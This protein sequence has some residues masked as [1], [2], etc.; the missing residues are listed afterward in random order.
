M[1]GS[2]NA[3]RQLI[4]DKGFAWL[5]DCFLEESVRIN[6]QLVP[7]ADKGMIFSIL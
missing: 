1:I 6:H 5:M 3:F 4:H 2:E 7:F